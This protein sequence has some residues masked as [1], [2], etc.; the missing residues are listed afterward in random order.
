MPTWAI[1]AAAMA[2]AATLAVLRRR[3]LVPKWQWNDTAVT[4][5]IGNRVT[6]VF[7]PEVRV[8]LAGRQGLVLRTL[9]GDTVF[10]ARWLTPQVIDAF[11]TAVGDGGRLRAALAA[12]GFQELWGRGETPLSLP[13][14]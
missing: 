1:V 3:S 9:D 10:P 7:L 11:G 6:E 14:M 2:A 8:V 12:G 13:P 5:F 4:V